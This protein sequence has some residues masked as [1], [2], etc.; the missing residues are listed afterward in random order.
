MRDHR[1]PS[2][3]S[4]VTEPLEPADHGL[5]GRG[6]TLFRAVTAAYELEAWELPTLI[7]AARTLALIDRLE[8]ALSG[9]ELLVPGYKGQPTASPLLGEIRAH[10]QTYERLRAALSLPELD[11]DGGFVEYTSV[12]SRRASHAAQ[13][14]WSRARQEGVA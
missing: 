6:A 13:A 5:G 3:R 14:R 8:D 2:G 4:H 11:D 9:A 7:E 10:R 1:P 12:T